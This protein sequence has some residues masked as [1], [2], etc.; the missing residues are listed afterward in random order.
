MREEAGA[1][2]EAAGG[3]LFLD[4]ISELSTASQ[5]RILRLIERGEI[6]AVGASAPERVDLRVIAAASCDLTEQ[7]T[8]GLFR[9]DLFHRLS[10]FHLTLPA[11]R[12]RP[13]DIPALAGHFLEELNGLHGKRLRVE[14]EALEAMRALRLKGNARELRSLLERTLLE[15]SDETVITRA[16]VETVAARQGTTANF[17]NPWAGCSLKEEVLSFE[18]N[19]V[20]L[21][22]EK[23]GGGV[24]QAARL[25][26]ITHQRLCAML[27]SRHKNL[28]LAKK[29][30]RPRNR[31]TISSL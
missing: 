17:S 11:L 1:A 6:H 7:M 10:T 3:T 29:D 23:A 2:R 5:G 26:H 28:L 9:E 8:R 18:S 20:G 21:A 19:L 25:L 12:E 13:A 27:Q 14:P 15:A 16:A 30:A 4:N 24:T 22:L 31:S